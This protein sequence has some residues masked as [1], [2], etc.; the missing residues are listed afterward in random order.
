MAAL[1]DRSDDSPSPSINTVKALEDTVYNACDLCKRSYETFYGFA[2]DITSALKDIDN[3]KMTHESR[4]KYESIA[5]DIRDISRTIY[6]IGNL[7]ESLSDAYMDVDF[8]VSFDEGSSQTDSSDEY[9]V[10]SDD[11]SESFE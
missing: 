5:L 3:R 7:M 4:D 11:H 8:N 9:S 1:N 2:Y 10:Y 6:K